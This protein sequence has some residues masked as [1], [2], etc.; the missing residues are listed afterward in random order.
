MKYQVKIET[1]KDQLEKVEIHKAYCGA[2]MEDPCMCSDPRA[3]KYYL[4]IK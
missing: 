1:V 3:N 4:G 2:G